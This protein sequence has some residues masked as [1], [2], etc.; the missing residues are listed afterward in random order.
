MHIRAYL[1]LMAAAIL[2]PVVLFSGLALNLLQNAERQAA[3]HALAETANNVAL[4]VER[5][6]YGAQATLRMQAAQQLPDASVPEGAVSSVEH[7]ARPG[8]LMTSV[9]LPVTLDDGRHVVLK[10]T[11][12]SSHFNGLL[13]ELKV[14]DGWLVAIVD[15]NGNFI[16]RNLHA[17]TLVGTP[18]H[19]AVLAAAR[20]SH[21]GQVRHPSLEGTESIAAFTHCSLSGWIVTVAAPVA[22]ID[23]SAR[24]ASFVAVLGLLAALG[25]AAG[26]AAYFGRRHVRAIQRAV[27]D[28]IALGNGIPPARQQSR[29]IE[30]HALHGAL[31]AAGEQ[32]RQ[33]Q[34]YRK[35]AEA[36]REA[37][38]ER[39]Q[40]ARRLAEQQNAAKDQFL[41][42]LGHE[43]R[44]PLAP[45]STAAQLLKLQPASPERV[46]Y[47]SEVISRQVDH[48][49]SLLGD[50]LDVARVTRGLV[51]L[52]L[53]TVDL[54]AVLERALEQT[55]SLVEAKRHR[56]RL[57]L[58]SAPLYLCADH[59]RLVQIFA[60]LLTNAAK[61]TPANGVIG[62]AVQV[63]ADRAVITVSDSGEGFPADLLPRLFDLFSQ[64]ER[65]PD[66]SQGGLGLG[67][68]LVKRLVQLHGGSISAHSAGAGHGS[69]FCVTLPYDGP[70]PLAAPAACQGAGAGGLR[71]MLV[72]DNIDAALSLAMLLA[73]NGGHRLSV[74]HDA[75]AALARAPQ[76]AP[77]VFILDVGLPDMN[78]YQLAQRLK[79]MAC[80]A[81]AQFIALTGYGQPQDTQRAHAAGFEHHLSK[82]ADSQQIL[83]LLRVSIE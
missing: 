49:N 71:I 7:G 65:Q 74:C 10:Q 30:V 20:A 4:R 61:Y 13:Q 32:L 73:E 69:R 66:R 44:N 40:G 26:L 51:T 15:R 52:K 60:N 80:C 72:D 55:A 64:G 8:S 24:A 79:A 17:S 36:E 63:D 37:L 82:P 62:V 53:E 48:M 27:D 6:L 34:H 41:A 22:L 47:A 50:L 21:S 18:A 54:K 33:A 23:Y 81:D 5:E 1:F 3:L 19:P 59:T 78:G 11:F 29:V 9:S 39:E 70:P 2:I 16:A 43:L 68:A 46:R 77:D 45:I 56:L 31:H 42:M 25:C 57:D 67:L 14:P 38:L 35:H 28:A 75:A 76:E 83:G 58:P 12:P